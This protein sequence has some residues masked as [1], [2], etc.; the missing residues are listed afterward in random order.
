MPNLGRNRKN[1]VVA[2][3]ERRQRV[4]TLYI[5]GKGQ[6][7]IARAL[8]VVQPTV[9]KDLTAIRAEWLAS[10]LRDFDAKKAEELAKLDRLEA[11]AWEAWRR[12]CEP[13][14]LTA[15]R[16]SESVRL[17]PNGRPTRVPVET[18]TTRSVARDGD[19]RFLAE[20]REVVT[21][22][23]KLIGALKP[24]DTNLTQQ[25][26]VQTI[27]W[28]ALTSRSDEPDYIDVR[29][30]EAAKLALPG[31]DSPV[32]KPSALSDKELP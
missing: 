22:R 14:E 13:V 16:R 9:S 28:D 31:V 25:T 12:S 5:Q 10:S 26:V 18:K 19:P 17:Q 29:L 32:S 1:D 3:A 11:V 7:E 30:A 23:L 20:I 15:T 2:I 21:L 4:A 27:D 6:C 8:K 24:G